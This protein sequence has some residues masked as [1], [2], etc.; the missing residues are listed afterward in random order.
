MVCGNFIEF[1]SG[2]NWTKLNKNVF[3]LVNHC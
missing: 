1:V 3:F 2:K